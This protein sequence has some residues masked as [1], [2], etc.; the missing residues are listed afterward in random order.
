MPADPLDI[1]NQARRAALAIS[2]KTGAGPLKRLLARAQEDLDKRLAGVAKDNDTFGP[3]QLRATMAQIAAISSLLKKNMLGPVLESGAHSAKTAVGASLGYLEKAEQRFAGVGTAGLGLRTASIYERAIHGTETSMLRRILTDPEHPGQKGVLDRYGDAV[4]GRFEERLQLRL[5]TGAPWADVRKELVAES[6]FLQ[7][8]PAH[9]AER[10][11]RTECLVGST[12]V[13]AAVVRAVFRRWYEGRVVEIVTEGGRHFTTTPNHPMLTRRGWVAAKDLDGF[14]DLVCDARKQ[15]LGSAGDENVD[16]RPPTIAEVFDSVAAVGVGQRRRAAQPDFHG[17][18][19]DGEVD[20]QRPH[21]ALAIGAFAPIFEPTAQAIFT[22][23]GVVGATFCTRCRRLLSIQQQA[24]L[25]RVANVEVGCADP[26]VDG[27]DTD[28]KIARDL[29]RAGS[30]LVRGNDGFRIEVLAQPWRNP[31]CKV[32]CVPGVRSGSGGPGFSHDPCDGREAGSELV[33]DAEAALPG[34]IEFDR[35]KAIRFREFSG[36]VYNLETPFGYF[37]INGAY[38]GNTMYAHNRAGYEATAEINQQTGG[39]MIRILCAT[40]DDRTAADSYAVHGQ[41]RRMN[42]S[43]HSWFGAYMTPPNRPNDREIIVPHFMEWPIPDELKWKTDGEVL[44]RWLY[45]GRKGAVPPRPKM[46]TV[47]LD[48]IGKPAEPAEVAAVVP[49]PAPPTPEPA[50]PPAKKAPPVTPQP[51]P[52]QKGVHDGYLPQAV[53]LAQADM[54]LLTSVGKVGYGDQGPGHIPQTHVFEFGDS[55]VHQQLAQIEGALKGL[56]KKAKATPPIPVA[57]ELVTAA[58]GPG[59]PGLS[60]AKVEKAM[61]KILA[62]SPID[63]EPVTLIKGF[64]GQ[65]YVADPKQAEHVAALVLLAKSS[66]IFGVPAHVV[67]WDAVEKAP[68]S[69]PKP[70]AAP[71]KPAAPPGGAIPAWTPAPEPASTFAAPKPAKPRKG[72][73]ITSSAAGSHAKPG[74]SPGLEGGPVLVPVEVPPRLEEAGEP[75]LPTPFI[76]RR[77]LPKRTAATVATRAAKVRRSSSWRDFDD[78]EEKAATEMPH[79]LQ[80]RA[81]LQVVDEQN[82]GPGMTAGAVDAPAVAAAKKFTFGYDWTIREYTSGRSRDELIEAR[83]RHK[84]YEGRTAAEQHVDEAIEASRHVERLFYAAHD[85]PEKVTYRGIGGLTDQQLEQFLGG[86]AFDMQGKPSSTSLQYRTARQFAEGK[87]SEHNG[88][89][90][91]LKLHRRSKGVYV[92]SITSVG[93][94][95]EVIVHGNTQWRIISRTRAKDD[96]DGREV[97]VIEAEEI[98]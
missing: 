83:F 22:P 7:G 86:D 95:Y 71:P 45:E 82:F 6:P 4:V 34:S 52:A 66:S 39:A 81:R 76:P 16:H 70:A 9:W 5:V 42:E 19:A 53:D 63:I 48:M 2:V 38:T 80:L 35:V 32:K 31:T 23:A 13:S 98:V 26:V 62:S 78:S 54:A 90:I 56:V 11:I 55:E 15:D 87:M 37:A 47:P 8:A 24:C 25:C 44:A 12:L 27:P 29:E 57:H 93:S 36:H 1:L 49:P 97:W 60:T 46:T 67:P 91:V 30:R 77:R 69:A 51:A 20:V 84:P 14:D 85:C 58:A 50:P 61:K 75:P 88:H 96:D 74:K 33:G 18:G 43:F 73:A 28:P 10:I 72:P 94:E 3:V 92:E 64:D 40:F 59:G 17:D 79:R 89:G 68:V 41:I 21:R 65:F